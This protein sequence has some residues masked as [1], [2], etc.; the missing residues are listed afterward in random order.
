MLA[1]STLELFSLAHS[2]F[3]HKGYKNKGEARLQ[4][5][6]ARR[7]N[8]GSQRNNAFNIVINAFQHEFKILPIKCLALRINVLT[9]YVY[10]SGFTIEIQNASVCTS[11]NKALDFCIMLLPQNCPY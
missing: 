2:G 1:F 8:F 11:P 7:Y 9:M 6:A 3:I 4:L 10:T 5:S